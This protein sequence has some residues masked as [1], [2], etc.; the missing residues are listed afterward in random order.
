MAHGAWK[1]AEPWRDRFRTPRVV[2]LINAAPGSTAAIVRA[3]REQVIAN[4]ESTEAVR[5]LGIPWRWTLAFTRRGT[6]E[7]WLYLVPNPAEPRIAAV[8]SAEFVESLLRTC[9]VKSVREGA[10]SA[11]VVGATAW[12]EWRVESVAVAR[13]VLQTV[14]SASPEAGVGA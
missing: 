3:V 12:V 10:A 1:R 2:D 14:M 11:R 8:L 6:D 13:V 7:P 5:W 9:V 4:T